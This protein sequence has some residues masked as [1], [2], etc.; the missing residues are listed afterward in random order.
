MGLQIADA[1]AGS[2][3]YAVEPSKYGYTE[4]RYVKLLKPIVYHWHGK[5]LGYGIKSWPREA[6]L[7]EGMGVEYQ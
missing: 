4:H 2:F 5:Y 7:P 1:V 3:F 6:E